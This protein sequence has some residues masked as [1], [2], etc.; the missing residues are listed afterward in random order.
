MFFLIIVIAILSTIFIVS[1]YII[2]LLKKMKLKSSLKKNMQ[3][4]S[5]AQA[6]KSLLKLIRKDPFDIEKRMQAVHLFMEMDNYSEAILQLNSMLSLSKNK[7]GV[8]ESEI[9]SL[10]ADCHLKMG[11][12]EEA[13]K[14]YTILRKLD[15]TN[16]Q[17][18]I[19]LGRLEVQKESLHDAL[20]YFKKALSLDSQNFSVLKEI[21]TVFYQ[22]NKYADSLRVLRLAHEKNPDDPEVHFYLGRVHNELEHYKY[23][24][25]HYLKA[26]EDPRFSVESLV[27]AARILRTHKKYPEAFKVLSLAL[28]IE[29]LER[30]KQLEIRYELGEVFLELGE[31]MNAIKQ[32][33]RIL[34][35]SPGY[36]DVRGKLEKYEQMKYSSVLKAYL[37][38][39][40]S[41]YQKLCKRLVMNFAE[42]VVIIRISNQRDSSVEIFAQA[43]YRNR[44]LMILFK[45]F[46]GKTKIGQLAIREFYEKARETKAN[47][48]ICL[49]S[50]EFT[51]EAANFVEG[52]PIELY[53][54]GRFHSILRKAEKK[55][56]SE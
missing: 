34:S 19:A 21:G 46:R 53:S 22:L 45:F 18:Y 2:S 51:D 17:A 23:A 35:L 38:S 36:R 42:N 54:G 30:E 32:W 27:A 6:A 10:L 3:S 11:N 49:T 4:G 29:D 7:E 48:G 5:K 12:V 43:E 15:P 44:N 1:L 31:I 41:D 40:Q 37:M 16:V 55:A 52:R 56:P 26:R 14:A 13:Y 24:L 9:N 50:T 33:E 8:D 47:L 28:K 39:T 25:R 20:N